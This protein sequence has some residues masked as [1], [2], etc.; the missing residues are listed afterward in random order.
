MHNS[1]NID[2]IT[3]MEKQAILYEIGYLLKPGLKDEEISDFSE[4]I[5]NLILEKNGLVESEGKSKKQTLAYPIK[6]EISAIFNWI[7]FTITP[8]A[9]KEIVDLLKTNP[10]IIR[11]LA[12]KT[13]KEEAVKPFTLK[14]R[15]KK[16]EETVPD[17]LVPTE[18]KLEE[19]EIDKK[20]E[21]LLG[22]N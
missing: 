2:N 22:E 15:I 12:I 17:Q 8:S 6:K 18:P 4:K 5:K 21:E 10:A 13:K 3:L 20:I 7:K 11:L 19:A 9:Q 14:P 16:T 1:K